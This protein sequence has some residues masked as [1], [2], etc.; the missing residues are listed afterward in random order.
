MIILPAITP[1]KYRD[2]KKTGLKILHYE[3]DATVEKMLK[4]SGDTFFSDFVAAAVFFFAGAFGIGLFIEMLT[5]LADRPG[6]E[7]LLYLLVSFA[8][9]GVCAGAYSWICRKYK[10]YG[11]ARDDIMAACKEWGLPAKRFDAEE[12]AAYQVKSR[13]KNIGIEHT[14]VKA[15]VYLD[16]NES[17]RS[18]KKRKYVVLGNPTLDLS[19]GTVTLYECK[20]VNGF[21]VNE[22][23]Y[24]FRCKSTEDFAL[25]TK[26]ADEGIWD[27][28]Y[29]S[30]YAFDDLPVMS[31]AAGKLESIRQKNFD[32]YNDIKRAED[33][34]AMAK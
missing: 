18:L 23:A 9:F 19:T 11:E 32:L 8:S 14:P 24:T 13:W 29:L 20:D 4:L 22:K 31:H 16:E 1:E 25:L 28:S 5:G 3:K 6:L 17:L 21:N 7:S 27:F 15:D 10:R 12:N 30:K 34:I 33:I 26:K 2:V